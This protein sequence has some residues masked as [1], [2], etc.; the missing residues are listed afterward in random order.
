[1]RDP[2]KSHSLRNEVV[3]AIKSEKPPK[4]NISKQEREALQDLQKDESVKVL[5]SDKGRATVVIN[6]KDYASKIQNLL[7]DEKTYV[8]L[9]KNDPTTK[10]KNELVEVVREWNRKEEIDKKTY[11]R[12]YPTSEEVPKF[13][14]L[15]KIHKKDTPLRPIV[16]SVGCITYPASRY[17]ADVLSPQ[18]GKTEHHIK[19]SKD[20]RKNSQPRSTTG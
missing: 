8:K 17:L 12:I 15:P 20:C 16:S 9:K 6:E 2:V 19:N 5:P 11:D 13:Y 4:S 3:N 10:Y 14:G 18:V 7:K 1:M